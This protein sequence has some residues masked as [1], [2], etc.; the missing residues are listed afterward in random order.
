MSTH[1]ILVIGATGKV[2]SR[3][4]T[5]LARSGY[6]VRGVSRRTNP[7][8]DWFDANTWPNA[9]HGVR[10]AYVAFS[11]D[12]AMPGAEAIIG[13]FV[14]AAKAAGVEQLVLLS[15]RGERGAQRCEV[16]VQQSGLRWTI[17]RC[18]WFFQNFTEGMLREAV[19]SGALALPAGDVADPLV[20]AE[21]IADVVV[22][23]LTKPSPNT[24]YEVTGPRLLTFAQVAEELSHASGNPVQYIPIQPEDF[25]L[26]LAQAEGSKVADLL[27][28][29]CTEVFA[30]HNQW[31][32]DGVERATGRS[33]RDFRQFCADAAASGVWRESA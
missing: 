27:T 32:G 11:P 12:L 17:V 5:R 2:G 29:I 16:L 13:A 30:G 31:V 25:R 1:P 15:G 23:A 3:V 8:F 7:R 22:A 14:D 21:D 19:L 33:A 9:L 26:A 24:V 20:D 4:V 6:P 10:T 28:A 18:S